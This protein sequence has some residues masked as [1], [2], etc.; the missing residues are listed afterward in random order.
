MPGMRRSP[1]G[2][3]GATVR[4]GGAT[5][6]E[7]GATV[8]EGGATVREGGATVREGGATVREGSATVR[9][10]GATV[11]ESSAAPHQAEPAAGWLPP[12]LAS[13]YRVHEPLPARGG[14]ADLYVVVARD[15]P[16]DGGSAPRRVAKVY[17]QGIAPKEDVFERV[18]AADPAH[19]IRI[20][21]HGQDAGRWW[22]LME[23]AEHGSLRQL[24]E[25]EGPALPEP[26]VR[27]VLQQLNDA[28]A[29]LHELPLEHRDLKPANVLVRSRT[30]L[31]LVL[32]DFGISSVMHATVHQ[33][34]TA[35]T[36][37]YGPPESI[38]GVVSDDPT[39]RGGV[40]IEHTTW[41]YWSL[42][43]MLVEMLQGDHPFAGLSEAMIIN[44]LATLDVEQ[45]AEGI[46]DRGWRTLCRGL[47]RR[48]PSARWG[49]AAV[50]AWLADP[51][52]PGLAV[53]EERAP[54]GS[55]AGVPA[56]AT[57][58][59]DG[60]RYSTPEDLGAALSR[61]WAKAESFWKRRFADVRTWVTD[62]LG[63]QA[64]GDALAEIDDGDLSLDV[65]VFSFIYHLAPDAPLRFRD[66]DISVE[67]LAALAE[68]AEGPDGAG[69]RAV[70]LAL[71]RQKVLTL[72]A[73]LAGGR[74][75]A[76]VSRGWEEAVRGYRSVRSEVRGR[77]VEVPAL[78]DDRLVRLI[79]AS[80]PGSPVLATLRVEAHRAST[81]GARRCR[82]FRELGRPEDLPVAVLAVFPH[83][84]AAAEGEERL[85]RARTIRASV[86]GTVVGSLFGDLV[87]W[88]DGPWDYTSMS[89]SGDG[90]A[91][92][93]TVVLAGVA[94]VLWYRGGIAGVFRAAF[95][96]GRAVVLRVARFA[97]A[98]FGGGAGGAIAGSGDRPGAAGANPDT[99]A[100]P[101][102]GCLV[103]GALA[104]GV[105]YAA[106]YL[107]IVAG[108]Y[109]AVL[110]T[111]PSRIAM[112]P[113]RS[114][115]LPAPVLE[116][117]L[118]GA[119]GPADVAVVLY[120]LLHAALG[121][122]VG[123]WIHRRSERLVIPGA[124]VDGS[125]EDG[126]RPP[127]G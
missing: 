58:D 61:D 60:A 72:A 122:T 88:S 124:G 42:G 108:G 1:C 102:C 96:A 112:A 67:G 39:R 51:N 33:T 26:L 29:E 36:I 76:E 89:I 32:T 105:G 19:L 20:D 18:R 92:L 78:D 70:L 15:A 114:V 40:V 12:S 2:R 45:L 59:F 110:V 69:A 53:A 85:S 113:I 65:Q 8:R 44:R 35:R 107:G 41:D 5:V 98:T 52:D 16:V 115:E 68:R 47:L 38:G 71:H 77:G 74:G 37:R 97:D 83:L 120:V 86:G 93:G 31:D 22:E 91:R 14:E 106:I 87:H 30:P 100:G 109:L 55:S 50:S 9:E 123:Y 103:G 75:L 28:L 90:T 7:G 48:T 23:Y 73:A 118:P 21:D 46:S 80:I 24:L 11:R 49:N 10:G 57:I 116:V 27:D 56:T 4:E 79:G 94:A 34:G 101:G 99:G 117:L 126:D 25:Q 81:A 82:W 104:L 63:R 66:A 6:R 95:S 121:G 43:M 127:A 17:R 111:I 119:P 54:A 13:T 62:G 125:G 84:V 64:L 3:A